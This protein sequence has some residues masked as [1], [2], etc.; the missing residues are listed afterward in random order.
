MS[1]TIEQARAAVADLMTGRTLTGILTREQYSRIKDRW[2]QNHLIGLGMPVTA[3]ANDIPA[4][5]A[6]WPRM[7]DARLIFEWAAW[8]TDEDY[9]P[10]YRLAAL[11]ELDTMGL[12]GEAA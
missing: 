11:R 2:H 6:R 4:T 7:D 3:F 9:N 10:H 12:I 1:D 5:K 8:L